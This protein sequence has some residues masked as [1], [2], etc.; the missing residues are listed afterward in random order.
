VR[1]VHR[2]FAGA[3]TIIGLAG[4]A[5]QNQDVDREK[6]EEHLHRRKD[7]ASP[8]YHLT[9][10]LFAGFGVYQNIGGNLQIKGYF[11]HAPQLNYH[12]PAS[13]A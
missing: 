3:A 10:R 8:P 13:I 2:Y 1:S 7:K 6:T 9:L 4:D 12:F 5:R 11:Y